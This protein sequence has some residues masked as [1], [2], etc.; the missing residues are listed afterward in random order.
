M[1]FSFPWKIPALSS[2]ELTSAVGGWDLPQG[3]LKNYIYINGF[4]YRS[5]NMT[6]NRIVIVNE[7]EITSG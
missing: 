5:A 4:T 6:N 3:N 2:I 1:S 7:N